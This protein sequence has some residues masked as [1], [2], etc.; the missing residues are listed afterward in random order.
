MNERTKALSINSKTKMAVA[1]RDGGR[2]IL[3]GRRGSPNAHYISRA[4]GGM[5]VERN[6]VTLCWDCHLRYDQTTE[7]VG[8]GRIIEDYLKEKYPDW[9]PAELV[10]RKEQ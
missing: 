7:R 4:H 3:C 9:D 5:G 10:Y 1:E 8:I 2:C 6:I